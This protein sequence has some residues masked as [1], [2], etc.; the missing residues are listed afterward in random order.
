MKIKDL[1]IGKKIF[2]GIGLSFLI[3]MLIMVFLMNQQFNNL[4]KKNA[5]S[6]QKFLLDKEEER[7]KDTTDTTAKFISQLYNKNKDQMSESELQELIR[8][9]NRDIEFGEAGYFFI[10]DYEGNT[11]SLPPTP[12]LVGENRWNL[13]DENGKYF[14]RELSETAQSGGGYVE[15]IYENPD[16]GEDETK[17]GYV[18][19]IEGTDYFIGT[20]TYDSIINSSLRQ[21]ETTLQEVIKNILMVLIIALAIGTIIVGIII[22]L[23]SNYISKRI[24]KVLTG[25]DH[26]A[27]GKLNHK[28]DIDSKDE[29]GQLSKAYNNTVKSQRELIGKIKEDINELTHQSEELSAS[30]TEVERTAEQVGSAIENVASGAEEQSAQIEESQTAINE[31][32]EQIEMTR[33]MSNDMN[34]SAT[35]VLDNIETGT[36]SMEESVEQVNKVKNYSSEIAQT[37]NSLG[38]LSEEIGEIIDLISSISQ[39]TNLLALNAAIEAARAGEAGRGFSV[40][41]D[42]IRELAEESSKATENI[43]ELISE[44]Q[45]R[46]DKAVNKMDDTESAVNNSVEVI[47]STG[48][49][50]T[51]IR[52]ASNQLNNLIEKVNSQTKEMN[53]LSDSVRDLV[54]DVA[55]VS[56]EAASNAEEVAA[57]SEEQIASTEEIVSAADKLAE[58]SEKLNKLVNNFKLE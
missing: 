41:A 16:T 38:D 39:Q 27:E 46:V 4:Q 42:E 53:N 37:I 23:I 17:I 8:E 18:K 31:L 13:Q 11:I 43:S 5:E 19:P 26:V 51:N 56:E 54:N 33:N 9:Y 10:Y 3:T 12:D 55:A 32:I 22:Y 36:G 25:M 14:L 24:N 49:V 40:V 6:V 20:G 45:S 29:I 57:S 52:K 15:Y 48:N 1:N 30:G 44:I 58:M 47:E 50:F 34:N 7:I 28:L 35:K 21:I 2:L